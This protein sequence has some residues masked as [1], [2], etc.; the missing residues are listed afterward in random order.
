[1]LFQQVDGALGQGIALL[2]PEFPADVGV[3]VIRLEPDGV[4]YADGFG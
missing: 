3:D 4:E 2:A 1:M